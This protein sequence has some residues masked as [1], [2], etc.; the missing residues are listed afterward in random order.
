MIFQALHLVTTVFGA[1]MM[2]AW[3]RRPTVI[4]LSTIS[5]VFMFLVAGIGGIT[6]QTT[7]T[8]NVVVASIILFRLFEGWGVG[9]AAY[10]V[11]PELGSIQLRKKG[12][13]P[14]VY[15]LTRSDVVRHFMR[16]R[17]SVRRD[18]LRAVHAGLP[19]RQDRLRVWRDQSGL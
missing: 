13:L 15:S 14:R 6:P 1:W 12:E 10:V 2:D 9:Q 17:L 5:T 7:N 3:G 4:W 8:G 19:R 11:S 18:V 16:R